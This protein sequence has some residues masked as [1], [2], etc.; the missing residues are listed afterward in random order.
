M[1]ERQER[2]GRVERKEREDRKNREERKERRR[3]GGR[4][5]ARFLRWFSGSYLRIAVF[6]PFFFYEGGFR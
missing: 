5:R 4:E 2:K 6:V 3:E 1:E